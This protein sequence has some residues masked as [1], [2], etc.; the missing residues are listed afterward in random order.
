MV[1]FEHRARLER[2]IL[3]LSLAGEETVFSLMNEIGMFGGRSCFWQ[4][5]IISNLK[6]YHLC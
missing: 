1:V 5:S 3:V 2:Q 4:K 6:T